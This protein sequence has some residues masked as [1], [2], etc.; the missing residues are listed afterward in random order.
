[1]Q[2][3]EVVRDV[4]SLDAASA[5]HLSYCE[6]PTYRAA[7]AN[8]QARAVFVSAALRPAV[9]DGTIALV[10]RMPQFAFCLVA[11]ALY[12]DAAN[13]IVGDRGQLS[14]ISKSARLGPDACVMP[15][16]FIG[17][18]VEIGARSVIGPNAVL[19]RGVRI[20]QD[21]RIGASATI[22]C[23]LIGDHVTIKP[24]ARVGCDGFGFTPSPSGLTKVPQLGRVIIQDHVE[25]GA[26]SCI[27]RGALGD[28]VIGEGT[29]IDNLVQI[30]H[31]VS[32]GRYSIFA[33]QVGISGSARIGDQVVLGGKVGV[34]DH[35]QI[36]HKSQ[37]AAKA[38]VSHSLPGG[39]AYGGYPARPIRQW[40]REV[41]SLSRLAKRRKFDD[42]RE[43]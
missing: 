31:N 12:P 25:I 34:A 21:C 3:A 28:T 18:D 30:A 1:M 2:L 11:S 17:P 16:A 38:G 9:P 42:E 43:P 22:I 4:A 40:R 5:E 32:V 39:E 20:G 29:K 27:D 10:T 15:G 8:T 7:L 13:M 26:N 6:R 37:V 24:G 36:G 35:M 14:A 33:S 23:A 41:A 19:G